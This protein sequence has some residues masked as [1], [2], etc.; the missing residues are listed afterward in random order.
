VIGHTALNTLGTIG[1]FRL[2]A[3]ADDAVFDVALGVV[4]FLLGYS[5][6]PRDERAATRTDGPPVEIR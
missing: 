3:A 1:G 4:L 2:R 5:L 6:I